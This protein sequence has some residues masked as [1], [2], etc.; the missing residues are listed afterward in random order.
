MFEYVSF[1]C[2]NVRYCLNVHIHILYILTH[3]KAVHTVT[4]LR[5]SNCVLF[6]L[7]CFNVFFSVNVEETKNN[8]I[9]IIK[10]CFASPF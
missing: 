8:W 5:K 7:H 2:S 9:H 6:C 4:A 3:F 1:F 10:L